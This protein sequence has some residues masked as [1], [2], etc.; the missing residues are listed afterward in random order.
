ML[1]LIVV[2]LLCVSAITAVYG[3]RSWL[4]LSAVSAF[5]LGLAM[6][7]MLPG[8]SDE[9]LLGGLCLGS[10]WLMFIVGSGLL[11]RRYRLKGS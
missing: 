9:H 5:L 3:P 10:F 4:K 1:P 2:V 6:G 11:V 7:L 8:N